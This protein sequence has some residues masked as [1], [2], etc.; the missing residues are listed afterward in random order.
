[1][2]TSQSHSRYL[3]HVSLFS[4]LWAKQD[5]S[6]YAMVSDYKTSLPSRSSKIY[7]NITSLMKFISFRNIFQKIHFQS[8]LMLLIP[9]RAGSNFSKPHLQD[10]CMMDLNNFSIIGKKVNWKIPYE[11]TCLFILK[12]HFFLSFFLACFLAFSESGGFT[13]SNIKIY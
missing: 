4:Y 11:R 13:V 7:N 1:M 5:P 9:D 6:Q 2:E 12:A 10:C 8:V 3:L